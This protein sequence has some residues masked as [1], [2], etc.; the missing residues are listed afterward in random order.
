MSVS[1]NHASGQIDRLGR[2]SLD[3]TPERLGATLKTE[4]PSQK[5]ARNLIRTREK[6]RNH[7]APDRSTHPFELRLNH[8][9]ML[10]ERLCDIER[11]KCHCDAEEKEGFCEVLS[12]TDSMHHCV[13]ENSDQSDKKIEG[14]NNSLSPDL[15]PNPKASGDG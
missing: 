4:N 9:P 8:I 10:V 5:A 11:R 3:P 6:K 2:S 7:L 1:L 15:L 12:W 14:K 13:C